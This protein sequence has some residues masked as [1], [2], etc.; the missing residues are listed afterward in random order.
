MGITIRERGQK[1]ADCLQSNVKQTVRAIA[2]ATGLDKSSV[3][4]H[5]QGIERR[6]QHPESDWWETEKGYQWLFRLIYGVVYCFGIK[7]GVGAE[8]LSEFIHMVQLENHVASSPSALRDL[9]KRVSQLIIDYGEVQAKHCQPSPGQ[10]VGLGAD[11]TF[12]GLP[13]L[14]LIELASGFI[15]IETE[16]ENRTYDTWLKQLESGWDSQQWHCH[17][18]VSDGARALIKLATAGLDCVSVADLFHALSALGG[19]IGSALGRRNTQ[20]RNQH[21]KLQKQLKSCSDE[22]AQH[23][24]KALIEENTAQQQRLGQDQRTYHETLEEI[25]LTIHPFT[26]DTQQWRLGEDLTHDLAPSLQTLTKLAQS[27]GKEAAQ[28]AIDT[29]QSQIDSFAQG[30]E[31]WRQWVT[32]A[33]QADTQDSELQA[34]LLS[35]LL[36]WVYWLQ[37]TSKTRQPALKHRYQQAASCAYDLLFE[38]PLTLTLDPADLARWVRWSQDFCAK[39]QRTSSAVEG[40]NG[41]LAKLHCAGRGFSQQSLK[42]LT[43]IHNFDLKRSDGS[44]AAQRLFG[45]PF[46]NLFEWLLKHAGDLPMPRKSSKAQ[47]V[48]PLYAKAVPA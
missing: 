3:H 14:V 36:P 5:Q 43:I 4:R 31:A 46:P 28:K 38:H 16:C 37:Q 12:F 15:F 26:R 32:V 42:A 47:K 45:H 29:F 9:K 8:T 1:V 18:L 40:R 21:E 17:Y 6:N 48:K 41:Y 20:L 10:G 13:V 35:V 39:Y 19:P 44:T 2:A 23:S 34:W 22:D 27:Y 30:I 33:L 7:Q 11:E 24:L 25:S